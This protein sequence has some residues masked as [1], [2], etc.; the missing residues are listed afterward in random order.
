[1]HVIF[2]SSYNHFPV[3]KNAAE[4]AKRD[5]TAM[6]TSKRRNDDQSNWRIRA[7]SSQQPITAKYFLNE[8]LTEQFRKDF[9]F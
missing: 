8:N 2:Q 7:N 9:L 5:I 3:E 1:M 4:Y 6:V